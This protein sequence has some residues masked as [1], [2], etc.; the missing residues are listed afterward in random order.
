MGRTC[1]KIRLL[2]QH[3][4]NLNG[5]RGRGL[6]DYPL[7]NSDACPHQ[8][9][10]QLFFHAMRS[11]EAK[12]LGRFIIFVDDPTAAPENRTAQST[13]VV[14]TVCRSNVE[15]SA[16]LTSPRAFSSSTEC[17]SSRVEAAAHGR[18][19]RSRWQSPPGRRTL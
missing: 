16:R 5:G 18:G 15:L 1:G 11:F 9:L 13:M 8:D 3:V 17:A 12:L 6:A 2:I 4:G 10:S 7:S 19:E 14:S